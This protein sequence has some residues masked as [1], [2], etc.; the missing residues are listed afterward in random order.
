M[1]LTAKTSISPR[2]IGEVIWRGHM[3]QPPLGL[4][5]PPAAI[6]SLYDRKSPVS[7]HTQSV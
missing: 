4:L 5:G 3:A 6:Q 1:I 2:H 7:Q